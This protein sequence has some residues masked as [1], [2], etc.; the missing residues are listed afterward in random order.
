MSAPRPSLA[1]L[2]PSPRL[3][4][5]ALAALFGFS[6]F[7][8][9]LAPTDLPLSR[10][11]ALT[12]A[13]V[14]AL[15][16]ASEPVFTGHLT[17]SS[18]STALLTRSTSSTVFGYISEVLDDWSCTAYYRYDGLAWQ[19]TD[20][21]GVFDWGTLIHSTSVPCNWVIGETTYLKANDT[22]DC[23]DSDAE[24]AMAVDLVAGSSGARLEGVYHADNSPDET[25]DF[26]FIHSD[27]TSYYESSGMSGERVRYGVSFSSSEVLNRP[28]DNCDPRVIDGTGTSQTLV[29]DGTDPVTGFDW[30]APGGPALVTAAG[31]GVTFDATD[32]VAGFSDAGHD[33]DLQ[34]HSATWSGTACGT[35]SPDAGAGGLVSGTTSA[36]NQVASQGLAD[37]TCYR[38]TL[39]ATDANGNAAATI[40]SGTIRTSLTATLGQGSQHTFETWDLGGGDS[41][42]VDVA[43]GNLVID[44]PI[45]ELPIRGSSVSLGATYNRHD[46]TDVGMGP[47]WR[48]DAFR[49]LTVNGDGSV[50]FTDGDGS[51]HTFTAPTGSPTVSYTRPPTLYATLTRDTGATPDR[52]SLTYRDRSVD[53]FDE[54]TTGTGLLVREQDRHGNGVDLGYVGS[55]LATIT[56]TAASPDR[57]IDLTWTSGRLTRIEDWAW[58]DG[59][60]VVQPTATGSRRAHRFFYDAGARL[61]GWADPLAPSGSCTAGSASAVSHLTCLLFPTDGLD[62]TKT[63]TITTLSGGVLGTDVRS[64]ASDAVTTRLSFAGLDVTTVVDGQ[65]EAAAT[66][67]TAFSHT[68]P[69]QTQVVRRGSGTQSPDTTTRY[70]RVAADDA[71]GRIA[72]V[73]RKLGAAWITT[74]TTWDATY[75]IEVASVTED[76]GGSLA[77]T[78]TTTYV[79]SSMGLVA[80]VVEP[81]NATDDRWTEYLYNANNDVTEKKVSL[82]GLTTPVAPTVTRSCYT[83]SGCSTSATDLLLR[84]EIG[85]YVDGAFG[86]TSGHVEDITTEYQY[87][88]YGQRT[89]VTRHNYQPGS[90]TP[91]DERKTGFTFD[92]NGNQTATIDNY[93]DGVVTSGTADTTPAAG[94][95]E[96]TDLTTAFSF[97]TAGNRVSSADPR[98]AIAAASTTFARD[99]FGRSV[100][101]AWGSADTGGS[102][103]GTTA[104]HD[105]TGS[106]GTIGLTSN[107]NRNAYLTSVS[108]QD[109]ELLFKVRVDRLATG[110][111]HLFWAYL[112]RQGT[113]DYYQVRVTFN[114]SQALTTT[115]TRTAAGTSTVI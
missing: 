1:R 33:W 16:C 34:R 6:T 23:A 52:F 81:L 77:R 28:G 42:A 62:I 2:V 44:H 96:R 106:V 115:F 91:A 14:A 21:N 30:P 64:G 50:T 53:T 89:R 7:F 38:W 57:V 113:N 68:A 58:I 98:R 88:A 4:T 40:T 9:S 71:H 90:G 95:S 93:V 22:T 31:V 86:G 56:D 107:T 97:D 76:S 13:P 35:F 46:P 54:L 111:D 74:A 12:P 84:S 43:T 26:M 63:Q 20:G 15:G 61:I 10:P 87:D 24:Y 70:S 114:T 72:T 25:G 101:D 67:G 108:A 32:A 65:Q 29:V 18:G 55:E 5:V 104:D 100:A 37:E 51:R 73:A 19:R 105:V 92:A 80:K 3:R 48:L 83:T 39:A 36:V 45:L 66:A 110:S 85:N 94:S 49:R 8:V 17:G 99:A 47:G 59:W 82:E 79:A 109:A 112:R 41:L 103:S 78:T 11:E 75:P 69:Y 60:G 27:C 102:W